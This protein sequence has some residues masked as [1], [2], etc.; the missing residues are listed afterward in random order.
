MLLQWQK[1]KWGTAAPDTRAHVAVRPSFVA[2]LP[3]IIPWLRGWK[4]ENF[5]SLSMGH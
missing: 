1:P 2:L 5:Q 4:G 3:W